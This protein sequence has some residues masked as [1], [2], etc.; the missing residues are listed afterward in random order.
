MYNI[1]TFSVAELAAPVLPPY[2]VLLDMRARARTHTH[3]RPH[4]HARTHA[5]TRVRTH[6]SPHPPARPA[7]L[8]NR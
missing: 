3:A 4:A 6:T 2:P 1:R 8:C 7:R 5:R